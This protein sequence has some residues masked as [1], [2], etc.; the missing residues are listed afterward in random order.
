M[1]ERA[2]F[3]AHDSYILGLLFTGDSQ[4]LGSCG[5]DK[6]IKLWSVADWTLQAELPISTKVASST[7]FSPDGRWL[8]I[9]GAD[10]KIRI[11]QRP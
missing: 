5:M 1:D 10:R 6:A 9:G 8:A 7:A 3:E 11:W 4:T 2:I